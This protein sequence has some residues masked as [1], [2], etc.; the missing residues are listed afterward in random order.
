[1]LSVQIYIYFVLYIYT[2]NDKQCREVYIESRTGQIH[3]FAWNRTLS[4]LRTACCF[5]KHFPFPL[6]YYKQLT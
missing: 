2:S 5:F 1:M 4:A 6:R 3:D